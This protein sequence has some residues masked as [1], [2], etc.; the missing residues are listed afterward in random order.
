MMVLSQAVS[1]IPLRPQAKPSPAFA[2]NGFLIET[3]NG[4]RHLA[5]FDERWTF[6]YSQMEPGYESNHQSAH[7]KNLAQS[8][9]VLLLPRLLLV[10]VKKFC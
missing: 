6:P 9:L 2:R 8:D 7:S 3:S 5:G 4:G 1:I 10:L